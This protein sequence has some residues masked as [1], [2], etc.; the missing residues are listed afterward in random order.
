MFR[1]LQIRKDTPSLIDAKDLGR[2]N[3]FTGKEEDFQQWSK[4]TDVFF[5]GV[6]MESG[7]MLEWSAGRVTD[8]TVE[9]VEFEFTPTA[10]NVERGVIYLEFCV[11]ACATQHLWLSQIVRHITTLSPTRGRT[12]WRHGEDCRNDG[13]KNAKLAPHDDVSWKNDWNP[14]CRATTKKVEGHFRR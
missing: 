2:P 11:A 14:T 10:N 3:E 8:I 6:I 13:R 12:R 5:A 9:H 7:I 4:K 1:Q